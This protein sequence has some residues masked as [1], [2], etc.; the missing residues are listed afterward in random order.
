[1]QLRIQLFKETMHE[2][3]NIWAVNYITEAD[4]VTNWNTKTLFMLSN[5]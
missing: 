2:V 3:S 4:D 1:M 5:L